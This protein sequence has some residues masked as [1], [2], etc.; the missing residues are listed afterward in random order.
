MEDQRL[1]V[2]IKTAHARRRGIY[3][4]LKIQAALAAQGILVGLNCIKRLIQCG[5]LRLPIF[6]LK[7]A[8]AIEQQLKLCIPVRL[9]VGQWIAE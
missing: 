3:G 4:A 5:S 6:P 8:G 7:R 9:W 1:I 2:Y